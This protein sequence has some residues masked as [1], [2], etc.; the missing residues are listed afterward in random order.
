ML[1][2]RLIFEHFFKVWSV[3]PQDIWLEYRRI[4]TK[5]ENIV[6]PPSALAAGDTKQRSASGSASRR[7][8][9]SLQ[10]QQVTGAMKINH[11]LSCTA[12]Q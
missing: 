3:F 12:N 9:T 8:F 1:I 2:Q 11:L 5:S 4:N 6:A 10:Q 7:L